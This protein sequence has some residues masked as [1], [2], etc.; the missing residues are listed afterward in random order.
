MSQCEGAGAEELGCSPL[1]RVSPCVALRQNLGVLFSHPPE[2]CT[3][4]SFARAVLQ[5]WTMLPV[6]HGAIS[7]PGCQFPCHE[8]TTVAEVASLMSPHHL[9][10]DSHP[11]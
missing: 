6:L 7:S 9:S 1:N 3:R 10:L 8:A 2:L 4:W 11:Y 5:S